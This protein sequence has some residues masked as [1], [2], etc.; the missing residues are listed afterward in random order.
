MCNYPQFRIPVLALSLLA[1]AA[2][3]SS[4][5]GAVIP[6]SINYQG[7][8]LDS[9]GK[10]VPNGTHD[11]VFRFYDAETGGN[12]LWSEEHLDV[13][14][15]GGLF[16]VNLGSINE[17]TPDVVTPPPS[18]TESFFDIF[19]EVTTDGELMEPRT[20]LSSAPYAMMTH[21][22]DGDITTAPGSLSIIN[23]VGFNYEKIKWNVGGGESF[24]VDSHLVQSSG[25]IRAGARTPDLAEAGVVRRTGGAPGAVSRVIHVEHHRR[26][27][28]YGHDVVPNIIVD[29]NGAGEGSAGSGVVDEAGLAAVNPQVADPAV[30]H[31]EAVGIAAVVPT[32]DG[33][34]D[35]AV[36]SVGQL[37][38]V[39]AAVQRE[40]VGGAASGGGGGGLGG[41]EGFAGGIDAGDDEVVGDAVGQAGVGVGGRG[42]A[43]L[44]VGISAA[45]G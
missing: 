37:H 6:M 2:S 28:T 3:V 32:L 30:G 27:R 45:G 13:P 44:H 25:Q 26:A 19:L 14:V 1:L 34:V 12:L 31:D 5:V 10:P 8:L 42:D 33:E 41:V 9:E 29:G 43:R 24:A 22:V 40:G 15:S 23:Q 21:R 17:I 4:G 35:V 39:V 38:E 36:R 20:P 7:R 16:Q 11:F 18:P